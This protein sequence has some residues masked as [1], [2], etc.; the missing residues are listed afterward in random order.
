IVA[1]L[2][3]E[4]PLSK[5]YGPR[6]DKLANEYRDQRVAFLGINSNRQDRPTEIAHYVRRHDIRFPLL[7]DPGNRVAD[8]FAAVRPPEV[9]VLVSERT[10]RYWGAIDDQFGVGY[11]RPDATE[12]FLVRAINELLAGQPVSRPGA[13][14]VGCRIGRKSRKV[15]TGHVTYAKEISRILQR[16]CVECHRDGGIA[17]FALDSYAE[18]AG[19]AET[20][21]EVVT[22]ER[23]PPWHANPKYGH[24]SNDNRMPQPE[25]QIL[26]QWIDNGA[27]EGSSADL[28]QP[29][30]FVDGW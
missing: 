14:S 21:R 6:L 15:P 4:C 11:S 12:R 8:Q 20:I 16:R 10:V 9:F 30:A 24:F 22:D 7:K 26:C 3:T 25:R 19:W 13:P 29:A 1:F 5:L 2:G 27:P 23:M 28:P 17:P 18:V